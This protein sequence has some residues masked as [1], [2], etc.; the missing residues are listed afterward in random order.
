MGDNKMNYAKKEADVAKIGRV[1]YVEAPFDEAL[2][3][4]KSKNGKIITMSD[5]AYSR[6]Q[7]DVNHSLSQNGSCVREGPLLVPKSDHNKILLRNSLVLKN[8]ALATQSHRDG[9]EY[10]LGDNFNVE[11][12]L[13]KLKEGK[14]Y[15]ILKD[16]KGVPHLNFGED[17]KTVFLFDKRAKDYGLFLKDALEKKGV[18]ELNFSMDNDDYINEQKCP[19]ANQLWLHRLGDNSDVDGSYSNLNNYN[20]VRGVQRI[21]KADAPKKPDLYSSKQFFDALN[22]AGLT[23]KDDLEKTILN[24]LRK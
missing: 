10:F 7:K 2:N 18:T 21:G 11:E 15:L 14:D 20:R 19:F 6:M 23:I 4:I 1:L 9:N 13:G 17:E 12:F 5:L 24:A 3:A 16:T 8:P 22:K